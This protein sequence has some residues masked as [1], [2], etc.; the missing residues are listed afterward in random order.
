MNKEYLQTWTSRESAMHTFGMRPIL[1]SR[2]YYDN[3]LL[4]LNNVV[5]NDSEKI[6]PFSTD[7][8]S[9]ISNAG[10]EP[11]NSFL[12]ILKLDVLNKL[13]IIMANTTDEVS[14]FKDHNPMREGFVITDIDIK[15]YNSIN[16]KKYYYHTFIF[17]ATN[18]TRYNTI[19]FKGSVYQDS[20]NLG[21]VNNMELNN[22]ELNNINS[23]IYINN[24]EF[25]NDYY[26]Q[27]NII[28]K[29]SYESLPGY[30][31]NYREYNGPGNYDTL[32]KDLEGYY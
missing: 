17:G 31:L 22:M 24:L 26:S 19:T 12:E 4:Y 9:P 29:E 3:I 11:T 1:S 7:T 16:N 5:L 27:T 10:D 23:D 2:E 14:M 18:T 13:N 20:S 28:P 6:I 30:T 8:Y 25:N 32:V 15:S 21:D